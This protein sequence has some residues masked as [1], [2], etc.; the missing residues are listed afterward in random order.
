MDLNLKV[1]AKNKYFWM[2]LI[3]AVLL[4][5]QMGAAIFGFQLD[6]TE[7]EARIIAFIDALFLV[8]TIVGVV[9]DPTTDG[10]DDSTRAMTYEKPYSE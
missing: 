7:F 1:R 10:L 2:T 5:I 6:V 8:L 9:N 4:L 3:P